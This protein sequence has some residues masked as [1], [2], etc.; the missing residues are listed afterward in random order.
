MTDAEKW[1]GA[2]PNRFGATRRHLGRPYSEP[3]SHFINPPNGL[4]AF[5]A[6]GLEELKSKRHFTPRYSPVGHERRLCF[7]KVARSLTAPRVQA[8]K[9]LD[10]TFTEARPRAQRL[11][12]RQSF[13]ESTRPEMPQHMHMVTDAQ[14]HRPQDRLSGEVDFHSQ[15]LGRKQRAA[16]PAFQLLY[17][18]P[19]SEPGFFRKEGLFPRGVYNVRP[20]IV[21]K[22]AS[23]LYETVQSYEATNPKRTKWSDRLKKA[24]KHQD[25]SEVSTLVQW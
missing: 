23:G 15:L 14:G 10:P 12:I 7:Q 1:S 9:R 25:E 13:A 24:A 17:V 22:A 6:A 16:S 21:N 3:P 20:P 18:A 4:L 8:V 11:H 2:S 19:E 5:S